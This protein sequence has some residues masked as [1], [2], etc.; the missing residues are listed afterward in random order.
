MKPGKVHTLLR[1]QRRQSCDEVQ[2]LE[3]DVGRSIPVRQANLLVD[4]LD[5]ENTSGRTITIGDV[6]LL[7]TQEADPCHRTEEAAE[8]LRDAFKPKWRGRV[9]CRIIREREVEIWE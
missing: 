8:G 6:Q 5:L 4:D 7:I 9:C 2:R 1:H 3:D